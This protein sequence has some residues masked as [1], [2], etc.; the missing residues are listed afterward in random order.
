MVD[1]CCNASGADVQVAAVVV[2]EVVSQSQRESLCS[3]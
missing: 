3:T 1:H 2:V